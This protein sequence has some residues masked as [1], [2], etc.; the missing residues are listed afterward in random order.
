[1]GGWWGAAGGGGRW[2]CVAGGLG[3]ACG[4]DFLGSRNPEEAR[5]VLELR[6]RARWLAAPSDRE[7]ALDRR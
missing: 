4:S 2:V 7:L 5:L 1:M 6:A 3:G